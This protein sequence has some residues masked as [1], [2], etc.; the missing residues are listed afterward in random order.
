MYQIILID[1][2]PVLRHGL[3][4]VFEDAGWRV[5]GE[6]ESAAEAQALL[7]TAAWDVVV[8]DI[9][10]PDSSGLEVLR[11]VRSANDRRPFIMHSV[12]PDEAMAV[13]A[14]KLGA[15]GYVNKG[16]GAEHLVQAVQRVVAGGRYVSQALA[17]K[18]AQDLASGQSSCL[19]DTLS[20]REYQVLCQIAYCKTPAEIAEAIGCN[21]NTIS[22]YRARLL[23]KLGLKNTMEL[24]RYALTHRLISH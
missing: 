4:A 1:D 2:H 11:Q 24:V 5:T 12:L 18:M 15:N 9:Q 20:D 17:E 7:R 3:R 19:H 22:T 13:R 6:A 10:L 23:A 21:P 8:C 16:C 14:F